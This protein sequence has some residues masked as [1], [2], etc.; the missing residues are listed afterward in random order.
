MGVTV[1]GRAGGGMP[2]LTFGGSLKRPTDPGSYLFIAWGGGGQTHLGCP[3][4]HIH[5]LKKA[6][7]PLYR[8]FNVGVGTVLYSFHETVTSVQF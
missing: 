5:T 1:G 6:A 4:P 7:A 8:G 2:L 3:P